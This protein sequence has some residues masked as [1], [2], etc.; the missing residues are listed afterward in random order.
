MDS[1][2]QT[3]IIAIIAVFLFLALF[4]FLIIKLMRWQKKKVWTHT[5]VIADTLNIILDGRDDPKFYKRF[6]VLSGKYKNRQLN[7]YTEMRG[8][9]KHRHYVT[10]L[11]IACA[12]HTDNTLTIWKEGSFSKIGKAFGMQDIVTG[13]DDFDKRFVLRSKNP[14]FAQKVFNQ[15]VSDKFLDSA[16]LIGTSLYF[17]NGYFS[18]TEQLLIANDITRQRYMNVIDLFTLLAERVETLPRN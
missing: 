11:Q 10:V 12:S 9:G 2:S 8:S 4:I 7:I 1:E 14:D 17:E 16:K 15:K 6:P 18:Y 13:F 5:G 3:Q